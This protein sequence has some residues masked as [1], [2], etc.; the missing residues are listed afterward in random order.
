MYT[1]KRQSSSNDDASAE[2]VLHFCLKSF[3]FISAN[4]VE[5]SLKDQF[6]LEATAKLWLEAVNKGLK[7]IFWKVVNACAVE[8]DMK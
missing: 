2:C 3:A 6:Y 5:S 7:S 4:D 8:S 1:P